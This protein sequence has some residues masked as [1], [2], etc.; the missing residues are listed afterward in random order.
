MVLFALHFP[1]RTIL[2]FFVLPVPVWVLVVIQVVQDSIV[3]V[4]QAAGGDQL[5][6]RVAVSVHLGGALFALLYYRMQW[7]LTGFWGRVGAWRAQR[8]RPRLRVYREE[9]QR[10][11]EPVPAGAP[12]SA[13][14]L[15]EQL[16]AKLDAVLEKVARSGQDSLTESER[17]ILLRASEIYKRRRS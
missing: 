9:P 16:E 1:H 6:T 5:K 2:L 11:A 13:G 15:D 12:P 14:D 4:D 17:Q 10:P 7:R 3:F 8:A